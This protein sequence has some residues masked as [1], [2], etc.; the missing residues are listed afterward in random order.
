MGRRKKEEKKNRTRKQKR[1][2]AEPIARG[3]T[4]YDR[5][6]IASFKLHLSHNI[7]LV[8]SIDKTPLYNTL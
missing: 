6:E 7:E 3:K 5:V 1:H 4:R 2:R 8:Y